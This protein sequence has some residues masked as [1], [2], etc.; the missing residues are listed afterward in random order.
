MATGA[1]HRS[2]EKGVSR[3]RTGW[4]VRWK[5]GYA[6]VTRRVSF[7]FPANRAV[8][9]IFHNDTRIGELLANGVGALEVPAPLGG[10]ALFDEGIDFGSAE[11]RLRGA[12]T[13]LL[14]FCLVIVEEER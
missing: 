9:R 5:A 10:L 3:R 14:Q 6:R 7:V 2:E 4:V 11:T 12:E 1:K 13:E 8:F